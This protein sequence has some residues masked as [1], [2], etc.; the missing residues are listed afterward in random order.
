[1]NKRFL[2]FVPYLEYRN[3]TK[4][5]EQFWSLDQLKNLEFSI[6]KVGFQT[7]HILIFIV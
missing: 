3:L 5:L 6:E 7:G 1:M 4:Q 2:E